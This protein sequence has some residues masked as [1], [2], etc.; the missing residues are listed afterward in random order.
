MGVLEWLFTLKGTPE[1]I[2]L[3]FTCS[4]PL[5]LGIF[6]AEPEVREHP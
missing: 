3:H 4:L 2:P 6:L 5:P 1:R